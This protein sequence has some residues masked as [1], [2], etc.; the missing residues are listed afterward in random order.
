MTINVNMTMIIN[1]IVTT[2]RPNLDICFT[3]MGNLSPSTT[4]SNTL[5]SR[6]WA[7]H[8]MDL[9]KACQEMSIATRMRIPWV[10][11]V[12]SPRLPTDPKLIGSRTKDG[13]WRFTHSE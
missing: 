10:C 3:Q 13:D 8:Q 12:F 2:I 9:S 6:R 4:F 7:S 11:D 1:T 5:V